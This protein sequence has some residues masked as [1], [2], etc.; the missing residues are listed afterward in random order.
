MSQT[1]TFFPKSAETFDN[2]IGTNGF[3]CVEFAS[4]DPSRLQKLFDNLG[5]T[6]IA[7]HT[8]Q[9]ILLYRQGDINFLINAEPRSFAASF[10]SEHGPCASAMGFRVKDAKLALQ[11]LVDRGAEPYQ[12]TNIPFNVPA[13][14]GI[15]GSLIYLIDDYE[16]QRLYRQ[17]FEP[18]STQST[19][20]V[21]LTYLD[22]V[23]HNV[24]QGSMDKW[25]EFYEKLFNF[26]EIRYFDIRGQKTGLISRAMT[27]PCGKIRIP[28]NE[29]TEDTSQI[30]EY[31][32]DYNGEGIQHIAFGTDDI[33][34]AIESLHQIGIEF[35][36]VPDTYYELLD[37]RM[38]GHGEDTARMKKN[39]ILIDGDMD[40]PEKPLLLQI[41]T[42]TL[43]GPIFFEII[44]RK[45]HE[46]FGEGNFKALFEAM[47]LD[48][49]RRGVL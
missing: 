17:D 33:Y 14:L 15:G 10:M 44:Q 21:G 30:E 23:T 3:E 2:P 18:L 40:K 11:R 41:F 29:G 25:T 16:D 47:E 27:S 22:H 32:R 19:G 49:M 42:K 45:G 1:A 8:K 7:R 48:Q 31:L 39:R 43:I 6:P 4:P 28:I 38:P 26:R 37:K 24:Y 20:G 46:G 36:S 35:L 5:F 9:N 12:D 34:R 13:I